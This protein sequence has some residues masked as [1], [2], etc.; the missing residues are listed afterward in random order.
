MNRRLIFIGTVILMFFAVVPFIHAAGVDLAWDAPA[1]GGAVTGYKVYWKAAGGSYGDANSMGVTGKTGCTVSGL[2]ETKQ[3]Y[4]I[5]KAY[6]DAGMSP[7]SNEVS[8][9]YAD[10]TPPIQVQGVQAS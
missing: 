7:A 5:V 1:S 8:W 3:Y 4:F 2:D 9:S 10:S 6:N